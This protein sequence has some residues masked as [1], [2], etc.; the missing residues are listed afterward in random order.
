MPPASAFRLASSCANAFLAGLDRG[1]LDAREPRPAVDA[2]QHGKL[3]LQPGL[4]QR[5]KI[6]KLALEISDR[7]AHQRMLGRRAGMVELGHRKPLREIGRRIVAPHLQIGP[8][9]ASAPRRGRREVGEPRLVEI[10]GLTAE[11]L[12]SWSLSIW[13]W[14]SERN[15]R[16]GRAIAI[17]SASGWRRVP[18][19]PPRPRA[20]AAASV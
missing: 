10:A 19:A 12:L 15:R 3:V 4:D 7:A 13:A 5:W 6:G 14:H 2:A 17:S 8:G 11:A 16:S 9:T 20:S 1:G 18:A